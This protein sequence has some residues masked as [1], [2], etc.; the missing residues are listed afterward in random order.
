MPQLRSRPVALAAAAL[1][2][3]ACGGGGAAGDRAAAETGEA[4]LA[5]ACD[6]ARPGTIA[7][8]VADYIANVEPRP[9]RFLNAAASDSAL[10]EEALKVLQDKG[11]T[12]YWLDG[13]KQQQQILDKLAGDGDW[14]TLLVVLRGE[15]RDE[16]GHA[17]VTLGGEFKGGKLAGT[18]VPERRI[19]LRCTADSAAWTVVPAAP[20]A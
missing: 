2:L 5:A 6:A 17:F 13:E 1:L 9:L 3:A 18:V 15:E 8:A 20:A 16:P 12:F 14:A 4:D 10:P 19:E 11:P 7:V